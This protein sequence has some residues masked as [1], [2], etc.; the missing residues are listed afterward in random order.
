MTGIALRAWRRKAWEEQL[1]K[2]QGVG[3][4]SVLLSL[5]QP[6][7]PPAPLCPTLG[8]SCVPLLCP[9]PSQGQL[10]PAQS[11][12]P[13]TWLWLLS[14]GQLPPS[15]EGVGS[16]LLPVPLPWVSPVPGWGQS[17]GVCGAGCPW[18][19]EQSSQSHSPAWE[20]PPTALGCASTTART[21]EFSVHKYLNTCIFLYDRFIQCV[22]LSAVKSLQ[23][24]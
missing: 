24:L 17:S 1:E 9:C 10:S 13:Y 12:L 4:S 11:C 21:Q 19:C 7:W 3:K 5:S 18:W 8:P 14:P 15:T 2:G 23:H 20:V 16:S 22:P 6:L